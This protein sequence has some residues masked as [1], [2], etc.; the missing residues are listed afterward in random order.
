MM[1]RV[2]VVDVRLADVKLVSKAIV[3]S[4]LAQN[5]VVYDEIKGHRDIRGDWMAFEQFSEVM[6]L[7]ETIRDLK[8]TCGGYSVQF[9][10]SVE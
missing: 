8:R 6:D 4:G 2:I 5:A 9:I 7:L 10:T 1:F 3:D